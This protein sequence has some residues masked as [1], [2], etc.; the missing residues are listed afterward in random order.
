MY[1]NTVHDNVASS[2]FYPAPE[3]LLEKFYLGLAS[4]FIVRR[5]YFDNGDAEKWQIIADNLTN[6]IKSLTEDDSKWNFQQK[7]FLL[8]AEQAFTT[9]DGGAAVALYDKAIEAARDHRFINEQALAC[10]CSALFHLDQGNIGEARKYLEQSKGL[11]EAWGAHRKVED[12]V[13][14]LSSME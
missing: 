8:E 2:K 7:S 1:S 12:I 5:G 9:G 14:L 13:S 10:E 3:L 4:Y 11:Y 6:E